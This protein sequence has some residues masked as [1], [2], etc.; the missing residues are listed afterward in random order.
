MLATQT[1]DPVAEALSLPRTTKRPR[2]RGTWTADQAREAAANHHAIAIAR[3]KL[4]D[5]GAIFPDSPAF[6]AL[7]ANTCVG[8]EPVR[9]QLSLVESRLSRELAKVKWDIPRCQQLRKLAAELRAD[10]QKLDA[11]S[12]PVTSLDGLRPTSGMV[13]AAGSRQPQE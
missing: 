11:T 6:A 8:V 13:R 2:T 1:F 5:D 10:V 12:A 7:I 3:R 9:A 4:I